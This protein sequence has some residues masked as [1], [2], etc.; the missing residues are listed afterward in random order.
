M[1]GLPPFGKKRTHH[2]HI[3]KY[4]SNTW[5]QHIFFRD[6]LIKHP[7]TAKAYETLKITLANKYQQDRESYTQKKGSFIKRVL[8][9]ANKVG[10]MTKKHKR[11]LFAEL[12]EGINELNNYKVGKITLHTHTNKNTQF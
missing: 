5:N 12:S 8:Q 3:I 1:K 4:N 10:T 7:S 9:N 11:N 2:I 6:Y